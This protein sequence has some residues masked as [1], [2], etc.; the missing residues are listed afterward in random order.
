MPVRSEASGG[1]VI[2]T[3][4]EK[5]YIPSL[6]IIFFVCYLRVLP[7]K[8]THMQSMLILLGQ[9]GSIGKE[10]KILQKHIMTNRELLFSLWYFSCTFTTIAVSQ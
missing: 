1:K 3:V 9:S 8:Y 6:V 5:P 10:L 2:D 4:A 7:L